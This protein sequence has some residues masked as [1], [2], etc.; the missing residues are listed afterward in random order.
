MEVVRLVASQ[1]RC[2]TMGFFSKDEFMPSVNSF[3]TQSRLQVGGQAVQF[4]SLP[5]L[6]APASRKS[7]ACRTP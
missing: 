7:R 3:R 4:Y 6:Q 1:N 5:A 2:G